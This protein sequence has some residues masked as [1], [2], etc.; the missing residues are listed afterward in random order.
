MNCTMDGLF[1]ASEAQVRL[2]LSGRNLQPTVT[3]NNDF[4]LATA[5][6]KAN[7]EEEGTQQLSCVVTLGHQSRSWQENVTVYSK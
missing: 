6:D 1:P 3:H 5:H 7:M 4:L 2:E